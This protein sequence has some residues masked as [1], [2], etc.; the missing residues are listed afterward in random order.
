MDS[1]HL[2][3]L[4]IF[5]VFGVGFFE[6]VHEHVMKKKGKWVSPTERIEGDD[7]ISIG[8]VIIAALV[9]YFVL[10]PALQSLFALIKWLFHLFI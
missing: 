3:L 2:F 7:K 1:R 8:S 4:L 10:Y 9:F 5:I 6:I